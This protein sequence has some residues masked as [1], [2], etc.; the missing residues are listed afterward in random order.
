MSRSASVLAAVLLVPLL[1]AAAHAR[2]LAEIRASG[3]LKVATSADF[4]PFNFSDG[5]RPAGFEIDLASLIAA[6]LGLK[7]QWVVRPFDGL[8][9]DLKERPDDI[10]V[11]A[12]SHAITEARQQQVEFSL[13]AYCT[14]SVILTRAGGPLTSK[15]LAGKNLG[16]E[17]GSTYFNFLRKSLIQKTLQVYPSRQ[18]SLQAVATG[19]VDAIV[20]D[21]FAA[22]KALNTYW[23]AKL[24]IGDILWTEQVGLAFAKGDPALRQ[25][26]NAALKQTLQ[27][28]SYAKLSRQYFGVDVRC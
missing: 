17:A 7:V 28:G 19:R 4:E 22:L 18:T 20:T 14:T 26:V 15:D 27:D 13:P 10:D 24:V 6:R 8:L 2:T 5:G 25:A 1:S 3:V 9:R 12:A 21:R 11:V 16:T 23:K